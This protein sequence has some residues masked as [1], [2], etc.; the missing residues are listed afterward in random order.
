[1]TLEAGGV[2]QAEDVVV[3]VEEELGWVSKRLVFGQ[4]RGVE[5]VGF[6]A[7]PATSA[8]LPVSPASTPP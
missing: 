6:D 1:M 8:A 2:Q 4:Q 7:D 5:V 3:V